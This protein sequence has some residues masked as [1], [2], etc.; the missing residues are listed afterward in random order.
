M[1]VPHEEDPKV[2]GQIPAGRCEAGNGQ[3][4]A[5]S[6][7]V[8]C[9]VCAFRCRISGLEKAAQVGLPLPTT[10]GPGNPAHSSAHENRST[11]CPFPRQVCGYAF[12]IVIGRGRTCPRNLG[13]GCRCTGRNPQMRFPAERV[14]GRS[15]RTIGAQDNILVARAPIAACGGARTPLRGCARCRCMLLS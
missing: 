10:S 13:L 12:P 15:S 7:V 2:R 11:T 5:Y 9:S 14:C 8:P 4:L 3:S 6:T 1:I